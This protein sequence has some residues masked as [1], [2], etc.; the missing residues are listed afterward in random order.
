MVDA[1]WSDASGVTYTDEEDRRLIKAMLTQG[2]VNGLVITASSGLNV[3]VTS[4]Q[5]IVPDTGGVTGGSFLAYTTSDTSLGIPANTTRNIY[6][7]VNETTGAVG[8][9]ASAAAPVGLSYTLLGVAT[10]GAST[11]SSASNAGSA[12]AKPW[13]VESGYL[14]LAGGTIT[15]NLTV[16]GE[17]RSPNI[18]APGL[19]QA[20]AGSV[21]IPVGARL[22]TSGPLMKAFAGAH[23]PGGWGQTVANSANGVYTWVTCNVTNLEYNQNSYGTGGMIGNR[24]KAPVTGLYQAEGCVLFSDPAGANEGTRRAAILRRNAAGTGLWR[25]L[26]IF[27]AAGHNMASVSAMMY[28]NATDTLELQAAHTQGASLSIGSSDGLDGFVTAVRYSLVMPA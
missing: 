5:A 25:K 17:M 7:T 10:A 1:L 14:P 21:N 24:F 4:G 20:T 16:N 19:L 3:N 12:R 23:M 18:H 13:N 27:P 6:I 9:S 11:I 2:I 8:V 28:L 26:G 22:G 15:G